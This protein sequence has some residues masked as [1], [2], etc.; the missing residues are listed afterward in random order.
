M[1]N[2]Q[3]YFETA[4][5]G[6]TF[7][8]GDGGSC[9]NDQDASTHDLCKEASD[10]I[11][12]DYIE[13]GV[14]NSANTVLGNGICVVKQNADTDKLQVYYRENDLSLQSGESPVCFRNEANICP[15]YQRLLPTMEFCYR[16][17]V[18]P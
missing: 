11:D 18:V 12:D 3:D 5:M 1:E 6:K 10:V 2:L 17:R 9:G 14:F 7:F 16:S 8:V 15:V 13:K 4:G